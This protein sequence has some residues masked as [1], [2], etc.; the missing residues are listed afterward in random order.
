MKR[1]MTLVG[2]LVTVT[3]LL[4]PGAARAQLVLYDDFNDPSNLVRS[5]RWSTRAFWYSGGPVDSVHIIDNALF[6]TSNPKLMIGERVLIPVGGKAYWYHAYT[7]ERDTSSVQAQVQLLMCSSEGASTLASVILSGFKDATEAAEGD[8]VGILGVRCPGR[9]APPDFVWLVV[10]CADDDCHAF[11]ALSS[12]SLGPANLG[13]E[14][15]LRIDRV[16]QAYRFTASGLP[17][18][19]VVPPIPHEAPARVPLFELGVSIS[20]LSVD[21]GGDFTALAKYDDV[22][23]A[24]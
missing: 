22:M 11:T 17:P 19:E 7:A 12:G 3:W 10:Q 21:D 14:Y 8:V 1:T 24:P 9:G 5:D 4:A 6:P 15:T 2:M 16:G 20:A 18:Q 23:I 13:Q